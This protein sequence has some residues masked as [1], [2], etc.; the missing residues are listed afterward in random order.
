M[1]KDTLIFANK[2]PLEWHSKFNELLYTEDKDWLANVFM[3][4]IANRS[5]ITLFRYSNNNY[6]KWKKERKQKEIEEWKVWKW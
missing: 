1:G 6:K 4:A 3:Y 2:I 5:G